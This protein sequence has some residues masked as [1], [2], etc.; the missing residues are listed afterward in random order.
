MG[1]AFYILKSDHQRLRD[2]I[3]KLLRGEGDPATLFAQL[4]YELDDHRRLEEAVFYPA[5]YRHTELRRMAV[6]S[7]GDHDELKALLSESG[8]I[9]GRNGEVD[10]RLREML[11]RVAGHLRE[12][13]ETLFP[14]AQKIMRRG[15]LKQ[16]SQDLEERRRRFPARLDHFFFRAAMPYSDS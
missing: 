2:L 6:E 15:E 13:E 3:D 11:Q 8:S 10:G 9:Y 14:L 7:Y 4:R 1:D 16:L 12:E 5:C